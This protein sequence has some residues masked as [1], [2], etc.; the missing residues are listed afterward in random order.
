MQTSAQWTPSRRRAMTQPSPPLCGQPTSYLAVS[1]WQHP[2]EQLEVQDNLFFLPGKHLPWYICKLL[3]TWTY[4]ASM[5]WTWAGQRCRG[6]VV[7]TQH[8]ALV[9]VSRFVSVLGITL[10]LA[11][12]W[13]QS[14]EN[15]GL[16]SPMLSALST[17]LST[18]MGFAPL[19]LAHRNLGAF[20][21]SYI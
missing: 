2:F 4:S 19:V 11:A 7:L 20:S 3:N 1:W 21:G 15:A 8:P 18:S 9:L 10:Y 17:G 14:R 13:K 5:R 16:S 12:K 6:A